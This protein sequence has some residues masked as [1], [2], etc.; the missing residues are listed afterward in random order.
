MHFV[1]SKKFIMEYVV[2]SYKLIIS[3]MPKNFFYFYYLYSIQN[4]AS[5]DLPIFYYTP[6]ASRSAPRPRILYIR[7][8]QVLRLAEGVS[9][10]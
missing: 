6:Y 4:K 9:Y 3:F 10:F 7:K 2:E 5:R 1:V 8:E